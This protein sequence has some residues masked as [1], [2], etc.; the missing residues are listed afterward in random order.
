MGFPGCLAK[1]SRAVR[2]NGRAFTLVELLVV[3]GIIAVLVAIL[4]PVMNK[5]R[6]QA[7]TV[8]CLSNARQ[9]GLAAMMYVRENKNKVWYQ[10]Q[11]SGA[12]KTWIGPLQSQFTAAVLTPGGTNTDF[13][14]TFCPEAVD[15]QTEN[16]AGQQ[17]A[18][19]SQ[20]T[21]N[22]EGGN[23]SD[24]MGNA[25]HEW[26]F[27]QTA[28]YG[29]NG[30]LYRLK[31]TNTVNDAAFMRSGGTAANLSTHIKKF[32]TLDSKEANR[33]PFFGDC[34]WA[35]AW[36]KGDPTGTEPNGDPAP[37]NLFDGDIANQ[38]GA[39]SWG[40]KNYMARFCIDRH[41]KRIN[42]IF[43]DGHGETILLSSLWQLKWH[44][45]YDINTPTP[46]P[47]GAYS[48]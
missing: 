17:P 20:G 36:P 3:V 38:K 45:E 22:R 28:P 32:L 35:D 39:I 9:L 41:N 24:F 37:P 21:P 30:W 43:A 5:A 16:G 11:A 47:A 8:K 33:I 15:W 2:R 7:R 1:T 34:T 27:S 12:E 44:A 31:P 40:F 13:K 10:Y 4:L 48:W 26:D 14:I 25:T 42:M 46:A 23:G 18:A 19:Y 6:K 29:F